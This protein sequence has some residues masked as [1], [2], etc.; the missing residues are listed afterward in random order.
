[1]P[2]SKPNPPSE[3]PLDVWFILPRGSLILDWAGPAE[4]L[5]IATQECTGLAGTADGHGPGTAF[6]V[7]RT[8]FRLHF[9]APQPESESSVG[10]LISGLAPL[11][12]ALP[13]PAWVVVVGKTG[14]GPGGRLTRDDD[15]EDRAVVSWLADLRPG[16]SCGPGGL[17]LVTVCSGALLAAQAGLLDG[18]R[19]TT[20]HLDLEVLRE[21]APRALVAADRVFVQDGEV[22]SSAGVTAG[23]DLALHLVAE[24]CGPVVAAR[25]AQRMAVALRR[26]PD[27]PQLS[28]FLSHRQHL[29]ARLHRVQD[30]VSRAPR[31]SWS[32]ER[33][34]SV[35]SVTP[36]TLTRLFTEHAGTTPLGYLRGIRLALAR[37]ALAAGAPVAVAAEQAGFSSDLQLRR[38]WRALGQTGAPSG[39]AAP[40]RPG[41][42]GA[43][44][45]TGTSA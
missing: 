37:A 21:I 26:G 15:V 7:A 3:P 32:A 8:G 17:R 24:H 29:N 20:H 5:R 34:A 2:T 36:R 10:A 18:R 11:P 45:L 43:L 39:L 23:I 9:A 27:D 16:Q 6:G 1:M 14:T 13:A 30:A 44:P 4:A 42:R 25:T 22:W 40:N 35:A 12:T 28:P 41:R 31:E 38:A 33:M 19:C